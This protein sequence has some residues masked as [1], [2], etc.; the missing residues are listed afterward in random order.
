MSRQ[1]ISLETYWRSC[2]RGQR[3]GIIYITS[4]SVSVAPAASAVGPLFRGEKAS[5]LATDEY[6]FA[7]SAPSEAT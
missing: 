7:L 2:D 5:R 6:R 3:D 4:V 1:S